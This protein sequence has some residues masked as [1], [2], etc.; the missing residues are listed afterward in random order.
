MR[1]YF[2]EFSYLLSSILFVSGLR[3]LSLGGGKR[4][5]FPAL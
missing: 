2:I 1:N 5:L 4:P 3:G